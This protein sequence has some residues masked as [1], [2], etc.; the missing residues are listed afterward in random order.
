MKKFVLLV[1]FMLVFAGVV[2]ADNKC[3]PHL[4]YIGKSDNANVIYYDANLAADG[5]FDRNNPVT[6]Y[7]ILH[8]RRG[9]R[10]DMTRTERPHFDITTR[11]LEPGLR[12]QINIRNSMLADKNMILSFKDGCPVLVADI[13]GV[14]SYMRSGFIEIAPGGMPLVPNVQHIDING[15]SVADGTPTT[16]RII[17]R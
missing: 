14:Q 4:F 17:R 11:E 15:V 6:I 3:Q 2:F 13:G 12:W 16:E 8:A 5:T 9:Q 10:E 1:V 7:W